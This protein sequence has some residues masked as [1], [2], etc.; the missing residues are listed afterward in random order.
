MILATFVRI[1]FVPVMV[2][3][4]DL[5]AQK[6]ARLISRHKPGEPGGRAMMETASLGEPTRRL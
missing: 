6:A 2:V 3:A 5:V 1:V 4:F